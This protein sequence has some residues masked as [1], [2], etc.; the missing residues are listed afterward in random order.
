MRPA[1]LAFADA[2]ASF[3]EA[4]FV[5]FGVPFDGTSTFR[6]GSSLAPREIRKASQNFESYIFEQSIDLDE[7]PF[8]DAGDIE[9]S[10]QVDEVL[11]RVGS[12]SRETVE[13]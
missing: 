1:H 8:H 9:C 3:Q 2:R 5:I 6:K 10:R 13:S 4:E 7:V 12:F 11:E